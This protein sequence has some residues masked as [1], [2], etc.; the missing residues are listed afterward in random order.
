MGGTIELLG[1]NVSLACFHGNSFKAKSWALFSLKD[2]CCSFA[3]EAQ[4]S[5]ADDGT[6][7]SYFKEILKIM[8][9]DGGCWTTV[10]QTRRPQD[11]CGLVF[12]IL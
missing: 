1:A 3:T 12:Y 6:D 9:V 10:P 7:Y 8:K 2:P 4:H 11:V 5:K